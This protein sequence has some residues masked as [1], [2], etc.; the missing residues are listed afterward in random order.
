MNDFELNQLIEKSRVGDAQAIA[1]LVDYYISINELKKAEL[2]SERLKY[3]SSPL[4]YRKLAGYFY[5]GIFGKTDIISAKQY[6]LKAFE[7]GDEPSGYNL[8]NL[9][10]KEKNVTEAIKYLTSGVSRGYIPSIKLLA[11]IYLKGEGVSKDLHIALSLLKQANELGDDLVLTSIGKVFYQLGDYDKAFQYFSIGA[12]NK[13]LDAIYHLGLCYAKGL[14]VK[15]DFDKSRF[16]YEM[17][18]NL[19]EPNCLYNLSLYY[20]NGIGVVKNI[21][22]AD[23][24]YKQALENGFKK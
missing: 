23:T 2:E 1:T 22:L 3:I 16:Y 18:A 7:L 10:L 13:D 6:Y 11:S 20:R 15:Q 4:A 19:N 14:G 8:A 17:G 12:N 21:A 24:L 9:Y 5:S